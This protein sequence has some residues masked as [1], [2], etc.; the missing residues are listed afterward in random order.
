[1]NLTR[2]SIPIRDFVQN[3]SPTTDTVPHLRTEDVSY[4]NA[5]RYNSP[6]TLQFGAR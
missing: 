1:M 5:N 4:S 3:R 6:L 2:F